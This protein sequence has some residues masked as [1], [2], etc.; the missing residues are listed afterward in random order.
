MKAAFRIEKDEAELP[1][2]VQL[3]IVKQAGAMKKNR[4]KPPVL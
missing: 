4:E 3:S 2:V 1:G